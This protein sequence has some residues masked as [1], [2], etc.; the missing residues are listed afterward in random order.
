MRRTL[1]VFILCTGLALAGPALAQSSHKF[2]NTFGVPLDSVKVEVSISDALS[3]LAENPS[4]D[5]RYRSRSSAFG[6]GYY[7]EKDLNRLRDRLEEKLIS[8]LEK[9]GIKVDPNSSNV[10]QVQLED[11][12]NNRPTFEQLSQTPQLSQRSFGMGG[13]AF[14]GKIIQN[15]GEAEGDISYAWFPSLDRDFVGLSTWS[16]TRRAI[17]KFAR[18]T[19]KSLSWQNSKS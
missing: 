13:A 6:K 17:D 5:I 7:G 10:L 16:D 19:A 4:D 11:V 2:E 3:H 9:E 8:R 12:R 18:H 15:G 14:S 1:S